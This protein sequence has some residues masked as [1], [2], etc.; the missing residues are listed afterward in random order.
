M[1]KIVKTPIFMPDATR[2]FVK[3]LTSA[4]L[5][6]VGVKALVVNTYHLFL[7]PGLEVIKKAGGIHKFMAWNG[8]ILADSG[9]YQIFS[10]IHKNPKL[11]KITDEKAIFK[12]PLDGKI[13][14]LTPEKAIQIQFDLGVDML[15][16]LDDCP[17]NDFKKAE[18]EKSVIRTISWAKRSAEEYERQVKKRKINTTPLTSCLAGRRALVRG[19]ESFS[20]NTPL[21]KKGVALS[22]NTSLIRGDKGG[23]P[24]IFSVI[25]GGPYV[26]LRKKCIAGLKKVAPKHGWDGYGFGGRHING[27]GELMEKVLKETAKAIPPGSLRFAL[28]IGRPEDIIRCARLGWQMFDCVIPTREARHGRIFLFDKKE[29]SEVKSSA[30]TAD[31]H[32]SKVK[33]NEKLDFYNTVNITNSKF[34]T[35]FS[36]INKNS[37]LPELKNYTKAYLHHLF[38]LNE[39]LGQRLASLN[40][41]EFYN[42]LM[43]KIKLKI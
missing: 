30:N 43:K 39:P 1:N 13:I 33:N 22:K 40:N 4:D 27:K 7:Q 8:P 17:P 20:K 10:L 37:K 26:E 12:S 6:K 25:Q 3:T 41:L 29:K 5:K 14:E 16:A 38:K 18:I 28:G 34:K 2:G 32:Q 15:V 42:E 36:A 11:G 9:G 21:A 23:Y 35:D 24:L 31:R 19:A